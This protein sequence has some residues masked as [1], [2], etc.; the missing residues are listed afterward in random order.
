[1]VARAAR[2]TGIA[3]GNIVWAASHTHTGPY[4]GA[5]FGDEG[6]RF[7]FDRPFLIIMMRKDAAMPYFALW[8]ANSEL[9]LRRE[10][11]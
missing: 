6:R 2:R 11:Q 8:V 7:A 4:T 9:L 3:P 10:A 1:M 5:L